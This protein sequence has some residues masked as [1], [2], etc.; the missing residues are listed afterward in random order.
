MEVKDGAIASFFIPEPHI[1]PAAKIDLKNLLT[2][3]T[4][5]FITFYLLAEFQVFMFAK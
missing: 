3:I 1:K 2:L 4:P 5:G